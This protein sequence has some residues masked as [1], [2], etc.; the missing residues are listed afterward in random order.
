MAAARKHKDNL[1]QTAAE[2]FR[3]QGYSGT[4]LNQILE[5]SGAPKGSLYHYFPLGKESLGAAAVTMAGKT[6]SNT[7]LQLKAN[8]VSPAD[9]IS[10]YC[11][12]LAKWMEDSGFSSGCPIA[13]TVL[14]T[15]PESIS[16][17]R[18]GAE[19]F[20]DWIGIIEQVYL[21]D[22]LSKEHARESAVSC[23]ASLEGALILA[24]TFS[25]VDPILTVKANL[26]AHC[27]RK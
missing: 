13:T 4:G 6:A 11:N 23:V 27:Q 22:A 21:A 14:E 17:Q 26:M 18:A 15:C 20:E 9:F 1:V 8:S 3:K 2:L 7:L 24:R 25:S 19:V 10:Q 5:S 12:L 16:I